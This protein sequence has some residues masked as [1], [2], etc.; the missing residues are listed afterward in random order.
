MSSPMTNLEPFYVVDTHAL[1]WYLQNDR[2]LSSRAKAIFHSAEQN[3]TLVIVSAIAVA[4]LYY[5]NMKNKWFADFAT[6]CADITSKPFIRFVPVDH[7]HIPDFALDAGV[8]EMHD[9][10]IVGVA[11]CLAAPLV[12]SD[13]LI[14]SAGIV[15]TIW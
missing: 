4:E 5:A 9:R 12:T 14:T 2:K 15:T 1:I 7:T 10:I 8:P 13:P 11:R 3:Q 6:L